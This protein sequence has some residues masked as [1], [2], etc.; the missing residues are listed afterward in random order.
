[1]RS[2]EHSKIFPKCFRIT[3]EQEKKNSAQKKAV[4]QDTVTICGFKWN[5]N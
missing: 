5:V 3:K 1:M 4:G 2:Q